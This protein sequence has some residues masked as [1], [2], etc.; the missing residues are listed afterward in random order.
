MGNV[1]KLLTL[2]Q[3]AKFC[4]D[5]NFLT[6]N[7]KDSGYTLSVQV[8][9]D[10]VFE[11]DKEDDSLMFV[12]VKVCHTLL[13]RNKS[14]ISEDN[15]KKAMPSLKYK[16]LLA[17]IVEDANGELDFNGHD[18]NIV[19]DE[20]GNTSIEYVEKQ[21]GTFTND[22]PYLEYDEENDKTYVIAMAAI[23]R[24][25]TKAAEIIE[26]KNGTKV[27]CELQISSMAYNAKEKYLELMDFIF[28]GVACLGES[29]KEGMAGSRLDI[30]D[31]STQNNSL[32]YE[33]DLNLIEVMT[34]LTEALNNNI[35]AYAK[36][37]SR[38]EDNPVADVELMEENVEEVTEEVA[39][40]EEA[41]EETQP[42]EEEVT[43]VESTEEA[44]VTPEEV[45]ESVEKDMEEVETEAPADE[46]TVKFSMT[47]GENT[48]EFSLSLSDKL[49][50]MNA[51]INETYGELDN[52]FYDVNVYEDEKYVEMYGWFT[53]KAYRQS[54]KLRKDSYQLI[55]DRIEVHCKYLSDDEIKALE[56]M[57][58]DYAALQETYAEK[59]ELLEK[60]ESEPDKM[61]V[62][63]STKY[64]YVVD[65]KE[66]E[67]LKNNHFDL[68]VE[69]VTAR[70][71]EILLSYAESGSLK[72]NADETHKDN[73][74]QIPYV[75]PEKKT[76]RYGN[77]FS[78]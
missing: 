19:E 3:L 9:G 58:A 56:Q 55:G 62:L 13:N 12:R 53:G 63:N 39:T 14:F 20:D 68:S 42:T 54:F 65:T 60:F 45:E 21:V 30:A 46:Y 23:P 71:N 28:T 57:K 6:F 36:N 44:E 77:L 51:L 48:R 25:Y 50:A 22:D 67:E 26:R 69:D 18:I 76:G 29:V 40:M 72:F 35:K 32:K 31:F 38:K 49:Y 74:R 11:E 37:T 52:D 61:E 59:A 73:F 4:E 43:E 41:S 1:K 24:D 33:E 78:R 27:S 70:A 16:P 17:S 75:K 10:L 64:S 66:F 15:M 7:S 5:N 8:P 47:N 2:E 34:R